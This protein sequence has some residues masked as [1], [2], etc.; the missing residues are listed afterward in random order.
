MFLF[1]P[2]FRFFWPS[3]TWIYSGAG[4]NG[5]M[6]A[7]KRQLIKVRSYFLKHLNFVEKSKRIKL[8]HDIQSIPSRTFD[9]RPVTRTV[10][11]NG[12]HKN[13]YFSLKLLCVCRR[14]FDNC[15]WNASGVVRHAHRTLHRA[16]DDMCAHWLYMYFRVSFFFC[17]W[18]SVQFF[19]EGFI[20]FQ[21]H[22]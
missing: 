18:F 1:L 9:F 16:I 22:L 4:A 20:E 12:K 15:L 8:V 13:I 6:Q 10:P 7:Q 2:F 11:T 3:F 5:F 14:H 19:S 17:V 21:H